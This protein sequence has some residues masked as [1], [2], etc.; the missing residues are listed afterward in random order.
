MANQPKAPSTAPQQVV[1]PTGEAPLAKTQQPT[2]GQLAPKPR[3]APTTG[4]VGSQSV[5]YD[6]QQSAPTPAVTHLGASGRDYADQQAQ[7]S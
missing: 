2:P 7:R 4:P 1:V 6:S 5:N 3:H